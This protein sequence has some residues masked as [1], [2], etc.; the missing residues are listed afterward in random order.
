M[1]TETKVQIVENI[2]KKG[3]MRPVDL[4]RSLNIT[5]Q[6]IHRHLKSLVD[7]GI[8]EPREGPPKTYY[9]LAGVPDF[10]RALN[11]FQSKTEPGLFSEVCETRDVFAGRLSHIVPIEKKGLSKDDLPLVISI[12]GEIGNNSFD[13]NLGQWQDVPGCWFELQL[14]RQQLW[15]VVAD[16][17]QGIYRSLSR[18]VPNLPDDQVAIEKAF[19]ERISGRAPE[20][21]GNGLKFVTGIISEKPNT[22][23]ACVS[24]SGLIHYGDLG[25][26]CKDVLKTV[27][28]KNMGTVTIMTWGLV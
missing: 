12:A 28:S 17:G 18:V 11:W 19:S 20:Q 3:R 7:D 10:D 22:G 27:I 5:S 23:L 9:V 13:H 8:I 25:E 24:G 2:R 1:L 15:I 4:V 6:A 14:T 26:T 21:R 16:R